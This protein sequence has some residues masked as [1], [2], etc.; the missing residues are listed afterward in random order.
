M[1][2]KIKNFH[3]VDGDTLVPDFKMEMGT[4]T[5]S[6]TSPFRQQITGLNNLTNRRSYI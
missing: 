1:A 6:G 5:P 3:R 2:V 4:R